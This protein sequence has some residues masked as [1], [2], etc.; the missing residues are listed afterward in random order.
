MRKVMLRLPPLMALL[1]LVNQL[2]RV[3]VSFAAL[4][5]NR[6]LGLDTMGYAWGA[7]IF[8]LA[9]FAFEVPSN[10]ILERVGAQRW[11]ARIMVTWGVISGAT[12]FVTGP[13]G[14]LTARFLLGAAEA[15]FIPGLLLYITYWFPPRYRARATAIFFISAPMGNAVA[16]LLSVPLLKLDGVAGLAGWQWMFLS[17]AAP[18]VVLGVYVLGRLYDRPGQAPWLSPDERLWLE[19]QTRGAG[20]AHGAML[21]QLGSILNRRVGLLSLIYFTRTAAMYG[22]SLFL[23]LILKGSGLSN[24]QVGIAATIPFLSAALGA[25]LWAQHSDRRDE[26]HWHTIGAMLLAAVGLAGAPMLGNS[27]WGLAT[28]SLAAI[29][30]YAQAVSFWSLP[31]MVL[32]GTT[33][34][35]GIAAINATGNLGGFLGPYAVGAA[36]RGTD[37]SAGLYIMAGCAALS[38]LLGLLLKYLRWD[39]P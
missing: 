29:G 32:S 16:G 2:D 15:G 3:N 5:M 19:Q 28:I 36:A 37:Y 33:M 17:E 11:I 7:G 22:V 25:V 39:R 26:R 14:F 12:A 10:L 31:P 38:A 34:A 30:L 23:P 13:T 6:D 27:A 4:T 8:F 24:G 35:A 20:A 21:A 9:Y 1:F 18:A